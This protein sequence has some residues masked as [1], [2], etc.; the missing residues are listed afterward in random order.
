MHFFRV[1]VVVV[2][3]V[4]LF[5]LAGI[6]ANKADAYYGLGSMYGGYGGLYGGLY[7]GMY[8][9]YG[10]LYGL[11]GGGLYG[12]LYGMYGGLYGLYGGLYGLYGMGGLYGLYGGGLYGLYGVGGLYGLYGGGLYGLGGLRY[13]L[14]EQTGTWE[15]LWS[16][17]LVSGP[18]TL[19]LVSDPL[20]GT[21]SG[22]VQLLGNPTLGS[23]VSITGSALNSQIILSGSGIGLGGMTF[24]IDI[25]GTLTTATTMD[26]TYTL[27]N[28]TSLVETGSFKLSLLTPVI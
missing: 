8:G 10:G 1:R 16:S 4:L 20:F 28:S 15:G 27:T 12:G 11:Y 19:N 2:L 25:V 24:T 7:G 23:L 22:Y 26:G 21:L 6:S 18:M 13:G 14:A 5:A 9:I 17:G 3:S